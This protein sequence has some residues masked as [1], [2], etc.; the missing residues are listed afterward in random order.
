MSLIHYSFYHQVHY[1]FHSFFYQVNYSFLS[2]YCQVNYSFNLFYTLLYQFGLLYSLLFLL[3]HFN[4]DFIYFTILLTS[5]N[6]TTLI[7]FKLIIFLSGYIPASRSIIVLVWVWI[8]SFFL[9][10]PVIISGD[11]SLVDI[12]TW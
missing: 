7:N 3:S 6:L 4:I 1:S 5:V 11:G 9:S 2:F 10:L 8:A 12:S